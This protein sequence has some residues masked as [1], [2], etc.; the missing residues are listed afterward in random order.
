[1]TD[2]PIRILTAEE[3]DEMMM[4]PLREYWRLQSLAYQRNSLGL[5]CLGGDPYPTG[6]WST[7]ARKDDAP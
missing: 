6:D 5:T 4:A 3:W 2:A 7:I 1:M